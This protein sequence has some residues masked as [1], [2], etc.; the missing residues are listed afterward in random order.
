MAE[1]LPRK[2]TKKLQFFYHAV[3]T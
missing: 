2:F 3:T 1:K